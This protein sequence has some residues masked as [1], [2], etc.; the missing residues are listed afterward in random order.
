MKLTLRQLRLSKEI[1][2]EKMANLL[3]IHRNTYVKLEENPGRIS[4]EQARTISNYFGVSV[5]DI[6]F[7]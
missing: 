3:K 1:S 2:Q 5:D 4:I 7:N 6:F